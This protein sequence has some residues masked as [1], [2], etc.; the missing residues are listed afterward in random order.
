VLRGHDSAESLFL[1]PSPKQ[2]VNATKLIFRWTPVRHASLYELELVTDD[3]SV[4]WTDKVKSPSAALPSNIHLVK[5]RA[6]FVRLR[7]HTTQGSVEVTKAIE[8][9]AE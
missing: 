4:V 8:F 7:V 5:N 1:F 6:Y 9:I 3:G 2:R